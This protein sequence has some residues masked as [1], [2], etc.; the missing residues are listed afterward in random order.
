[1][2]EIPV[3]GEVRRPAHPV[4]IEADNRLLQGSQG[5]TELVLALLVLQRDPIYVAGRGSFIEEMVSALGAENVANELDDPYPRVAA[6]WVVDRA[7]EVL[8]DL[9]PDNA[10]ASDYWSRWSSIPAVRDARVIAVDAELISMP[11]PY[12][13]RSLAVLGGA[14]YGES[15][16]VRIRGADGS[17]HGSR[18]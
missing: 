12:L 5:H 15:V 4:Q 8:I 1:M 6:E 9:S 17:A 3:P 2:E 11:G 10:A 13:D 14:L 7:P 18:E 16:G